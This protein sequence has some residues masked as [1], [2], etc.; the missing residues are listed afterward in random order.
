MTTGKTITPGSVI[1][2]DPDAAPVIS[3][4]GTNQ[5]SSSAEVGE[6]L[7]EDSTALT[8]DY[9][10]LTSVAITAWPAEAET[11]TLRV[12]LS[13]VAPCPPGAW[14]DVQTLTNPDTTLRPVVDRPHRRR[15]GADRLP[16]D[17]RRAD[18]DGG[19]GGCRHRDRPARDVRSTGD[20]VATNPNT[21]AISNC[22]TTDGH[23]RGSRSAVEQ[24]AG[25]ARRSRSCRRRSS[26]AA[27]ED[28]LRRRQRELPDRRRRAR[29]DRRELRRLDGDQRART[30]RRSRSPRSS[31]P[32]RRPRLRQR[33]REVRSPTRSG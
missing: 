23:R 5:S 22:V 27:V 18:P 2:T 6:M 29:R 15:R 10:D 17:R 26:I 16:V 32:S 1:S 20:D 13:G 9:L 21:V 4:S 14:T 8:W 24:R 33:V 31:S 11:A 3:L 12:C 19:H 7:F 28:V 30:P 25:V